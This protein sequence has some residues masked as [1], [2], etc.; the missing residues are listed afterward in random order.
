MG[1]NL[2]DRIAARLGYERRSI[3]DDI[4]AARRFGSGSSAGVVV[5]NSA[6][7]G[8]PAVHAAVT[9]ASEAVAALPMRVWQGEGPLK[10]K[11]A[12]AW[13]YRLLARQPNPVQSRF[14]FWEAV[15]ASLD[16]RGNAF[17]WKTKR[18]NGWTEMLWALHPDQVAVERMGNLLTYQVS[19][20][21]IGSNWV[22]PLEME[23]Y[24]RVKVDAST[25][26][27]IRGRGGMGQCVSPSPVALCGDALGTVL[28]KQQ[29]EAAVYKHGTGE[30]LLAKFPAGITPQ[31]ALEWREGFMAEHGGPHN[32]GKVKVIGGG[33][34]ITA[35][36]M[37]QQDAQFVEAMNLSVQDIARIFRVPVWFLG[38]TQ[39]TDKP[40]TPEHEQDRWLR[41]GLTPRLSRIESAIN[42]DPDLF[43]AGDIYAMFDTSSLSRGDLATEAEI[44]LKKVQSGQ[45]LVDEARAKDGLPPLP[46]GIGQIPQVVPV[47][48]TPYGVPLS[49]ISP[50]GG[51]DDE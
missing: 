19:V 48:G 11:A 33:A 14:A 13:Q 45:W 47:G 30:S 38:V 18:D 10:T 4:M 41:H 27:H 16:F 24:S 5:T 43:G 50:K 20:A 40:Q 37:S 1:S 23:R 49:P 31:Q 44:S 34:D 3:L 28:A 25:I 17:I 46:G 32:A 42:A 29:H 21:P 22:T 9:F 6:V 35:I 8:I 26:L 7:A 12:E 39:Q 51:A 2:V 36:G 15:Q